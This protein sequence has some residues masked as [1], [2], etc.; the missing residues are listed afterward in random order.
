MDANHEGKNFREQVKNL[1]TIFSK[2]LPVMKQYTSIA[3]NSV[4]RK[5]NRNHRKNSFEIFGFDFILDEEFKVW[6][7][8]VNTN[9]CIE[10]SSPLLSQLLPCM[11]DDA[12]KLT[13]DVIFSNSMENG[14]SNNWELLAHF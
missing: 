12:F 10:E 1:I 4:R 13:L 5:I 2:C 11:I 7:I 3:F 6:L 14:G 9:P 8:E